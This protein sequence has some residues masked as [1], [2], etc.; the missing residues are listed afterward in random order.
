[1]AAER[2]TGPAISRRRAGLPIGDPPMRELH[3]FPGKHSESDGKEE[4]M[5]ILVTGGAGY[6]GSGL[7]RTLLERGDEVVCVDRLSFGGESLIDVWHHP[8]FDLV[9]ADIADPTAIDPVLESGGF[10][11]VVHLAA[12]V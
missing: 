8:A 4:H 5:K 11:A 3:H 7:I 1:M 2:A 10:D 9:K 12:I 6:V